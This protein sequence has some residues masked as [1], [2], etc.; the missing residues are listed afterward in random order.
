MMNI[1]SNCN[2]I[3]TDVSINPDYTN[4]KMSGVIPLSFSLLR[5]LIINKN[6]NNY[7]KFKNVIEF[8]E[9]NNDDIILTN[10][11]IHSIMEEQENLVNNFSE[12]VFS[13]MNFETK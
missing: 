13:Y 4:K 8:D 12:Q 5:T 3:L 10:I 2:F 9:N 6:T 7:Y 11:P 1:L